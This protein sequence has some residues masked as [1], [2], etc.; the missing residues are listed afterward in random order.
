[1]GN[2]EIRGL[3]LLETY[4]A[5]NNIKSFTRLPTAFGQH[6]DQIL[7][8]FESQNWIKGSKKQCEMKLWILTHLGLSGIQTI[9]LY[10]FEHKKFW[11]SASRQ[12]ESLKDRIGYNTGAH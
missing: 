2:G 10:F 12:C 11:M 1:M 6:T 8:H 9:S 3:K 5:I 4:L 7:R